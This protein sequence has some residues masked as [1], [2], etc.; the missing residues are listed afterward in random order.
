M[1]KQSNITHHN[2]LIRDREVQRIE[3]DGD[4]CFTR[5]LDDKGQFLV[6]L[7]VQLR[8]E[9]EEAA[10]ALSIFRANLAFNLYQ[11]GDAV[12]TGLAEITALVSEAL[13][14]IGRNSLDLN[15]EVCRLL[16]TKGGYQHRVFLERTWKEEE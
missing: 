7:A 9:S 2:K 12:L 15:D 1:P 5:T 11:D 10:V 16:R 6:A 13:A 14:A 3:A 4:K 8:R